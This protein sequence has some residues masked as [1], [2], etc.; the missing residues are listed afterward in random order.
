[1]VEQWKCGEPCRSDRAV[2]CFY[3]RFNL[4][5]NKVDRKL[6]ASSAGGSRVQSDQLLAVIS[7]WNLKAISMN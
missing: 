2:D 5:E 3:F 6:I 4:E 1:M 7:I